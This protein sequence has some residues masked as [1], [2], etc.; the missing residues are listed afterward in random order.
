MTHGA[1]AVY[2]RDIFM[3]FA[4]EVRHQ[5][6]N[7]VLWFIR[8]YGITVTKPQD[9]KIGWR[10]NYPF[11]RRA[12]PWL[13]SSSNATRQWSNI[14]G[15]AIVALSVLWSVREWIKVIKVISPDKVRLNCDYYRR[16]SF[17]KDIQMILCIAFGMIMEYAGKVIWLSTRTFLTKFL[18]RLRSKRCKRSDVRRHMYDETHR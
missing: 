12:K 16:Y 11:G 6:L 8:K 17:I 9:Q 3:A 1:L 18:L 14:F 10:L 4:S 2:E 5:D 13:T 7:M 15:F